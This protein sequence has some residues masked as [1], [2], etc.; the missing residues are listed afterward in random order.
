MYSSGIIINVQQNTNMGSS[1]GLSGA[2]TG[3][4]HSCS[5]GQLTLKPL[6]LI[7][8]HRGMSVTLCVCG[9]LRGN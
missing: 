7:A 6:T 4:Q 3:V 5:R 1:A 8:Q 9:S 2:L